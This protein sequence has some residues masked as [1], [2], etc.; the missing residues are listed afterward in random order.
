MTSFNRGHHPLCELI[1]DAYSTVHRLHTRTELVKYPTGFV[2]LDRV[3]GGLHP[4][5]LIVIASSPSM[6]KSTLALNIAQH[7]SVKRA[8]K[9]AS[10]IFSLDFPKEQLVMRILSATAGISYGRMMTGHLENSDLLKLDAAKESM[11][12]GEIYIDD[13]PGI[14]VNELLTKARYMKTDHNV[15]LIIVDYLQ[16]MN[17]ESQSAIG[18]DEISRISRSLKTLAKELGISIIVLSQF[19]T[20]GKRKKHRQRPERRD[21]R[22]TGSLENDADVILFVYREMV[23]CKK[24]RKRDG[25]CERNHES[26]AEIIIDK[27][28]GGTIGTVSLAYFGETMSFKDLT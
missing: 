21:M 20:L 9:V 27:H 12:Q 7:L 16:L 3:T 6:G 5:E 15:G 17:T 1:D 22:G 10:A 11:R 19:H 24:C 25:S 23:Y 8:P 18:E 4:G 2:E 14:G 26:N 13:T 28:R